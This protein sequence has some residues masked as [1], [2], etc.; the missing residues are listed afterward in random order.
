MKQI[1]HKVARAKT[2]LVV[3]INTISYMYATPEKTVVRHVVY[4]VYLVS[5]GHI[6]RVIKFID[7]SVF[8]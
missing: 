5:Y 6:I 4:S 3:N 1:S 8:N 2:K 7:V